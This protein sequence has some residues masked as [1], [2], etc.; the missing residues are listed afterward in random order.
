MVHDTGITIQ[1]KPSEK[2]KI[3]RMI[4]KLYIH[5]NI[6]FSMV[7]RREIHILCSVNSRLLTEK[8]KLV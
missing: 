4:R 5:F 1:Y 2:S 7:S 6:H 8:K 3:I